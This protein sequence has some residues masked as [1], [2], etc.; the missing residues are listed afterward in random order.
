[1]LILSLYCTLPPV[2]TL[3]TTAAI[4]LLAGNAAGY[5]TTPLLRDPLSRR[6]QA[7]L[8]A[9]MEHA[10]LPLAAAQPMAGR[11]V[12]MGLLAGPCVY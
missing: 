8:A 6:R 5:C 3:A 11:L 1:M 7:A 9:A 10:A 2:A 4:T 12:S